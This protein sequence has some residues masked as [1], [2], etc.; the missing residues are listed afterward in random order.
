[1]YFFMYMASTENLALP[2]HVERNS[3]ILADLNPAAVRTYLTN[4]VH[5]LFSIDLLSTFMLRF[6]Y[7]TPEL[8]F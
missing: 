1:M 4:T 8:K 6:I 2:N 5:L 7:R 3:S